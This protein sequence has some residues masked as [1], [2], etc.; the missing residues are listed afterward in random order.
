MRMRIGR[1][2]DLCSRVFAMLGGLVLV[3]LVAM[4]VFSVVGRAL[5]GVGL[6]PVPGDFE[7][8]EAGS[9]FAIFC[10][11]PWCQ[12][13][14]GH[15]TVDVLVAY[16]GPRL[17]ALLGAVGNLLTGGVG[18]LI[19][20]RLWFGLVDKMQ[21]SETT[22]ILQFPVWVAYALC[23]PGAV[24]F[25]LVSLYTAWRSLEEARTGRIAVE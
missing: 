2:L 9:A 23:L 7:L 18:A 13:R 12:M 25:P 14:R 20:W 4:T 17:D 10:F 6:G 22:F 19:V 8:V 3:A 24:L 21:Y 16:L 15:V 5:S 11:M 1:W